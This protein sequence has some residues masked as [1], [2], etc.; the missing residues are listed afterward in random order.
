MKLDGLVR[1][2]RTCPQTA[3]REMLPWS[4]GGLSA[5]RKLG[6]TESP[7]SPGASQQ[8]SRRLL[9]PVLAHDL[10]H[11]CSDLI[12]R[13]RLGYIR[14]VIVQYASVGNEVLRVAGG[15]NNLGAGSRDPEAIGQFPA[16]HAGQNYIRQQHV[17]WPGVAFRHGQS[18]A[19]LGCLEHA[20]TIAGQRFDYESAHVFLILDYQHRLR[21]VQ[22]RRGRWRR[23]GRLF[24][25]F[26]AG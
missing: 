14:Y 20:V 17:D 25:S 10:A 19:T 16:V 3:L 2:P 5:I 24:R 9:N 22:L 12:G 23:R 6:A 18:L 8:S 7:S 4:P 21:P 13:V 1:N 26:R 11:L 15:I